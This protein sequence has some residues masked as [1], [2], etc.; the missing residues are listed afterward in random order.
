MAATACCQRQRHFMHD[1][2]AEKPPLLHDEH[3][4]KAP[5]HQLLTTTTFTTTTTD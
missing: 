5:C 3:A 4:V 2:H 1:E